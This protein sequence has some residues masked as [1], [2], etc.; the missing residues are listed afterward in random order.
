MPTG[1]ETRLEN[2]IGAWLMIPHGNCR[3]AA[4][5]GRIINEHQ[6]I[7]VRD[8]DIMC[9]FILHDNISD[10]RRNKYSLWMRQCPFHQVFKT[11]LAR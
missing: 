1:I 3:D 9:K 10:N 6:P 11:L 4:Q 7:S 5:S 2:F 8:N